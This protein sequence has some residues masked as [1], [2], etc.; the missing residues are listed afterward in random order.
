MIWL[1]NSRIVAMFAVVFLHSA[2]LVVLYS[3]IGTE[4]W[5]LGNIY[6][7]FAR[8]C[9]PVFVMISGALLLDTTKMEDLKSFYIKRLSKI[10]IPIMFWTVFFLLWVVLKKS[11]KGEIIEA[12]DITNR[13]LSGAPYFHLW[14]LYMIFFLYLFTPFFRKI[15]S[16]SSRFEIL[17]LILFTFIISALNAFIAKFE[18]SQSSLFI[19]WFLTYIPYFFLGYFIRTG[20]IHFK[21]PILWIVFSLSVF[22]TAMGCYFVT[23]NQGLDAGLYFYHYLSITVIPMSIAIF[24][25]L[26]SWTK[27]IYNVQLTNKISSLTLGIYLIHPIF[28]EIIQYTGYGPLS[29]NSLISIPIASVV[30]FCLSLGMVWVINAIPYM[31]RII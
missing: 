10:M 21:K 6:D 12:G 22:S 8:W 16:N 24:C 29:Y 18:L 30:V 20:Q 28:L 13:L 7:S 2:G 3:P 11:L 26:K 25:L 9:V 4:N 17:V 19:N 5:W 27:P 31:R 15:I 1:N 23:K 14:F